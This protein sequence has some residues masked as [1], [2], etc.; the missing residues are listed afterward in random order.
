MFRYSYIC[1]NNLTA[2]VSVDLQTTPDETVETIT[3]EIVGHI[4]SEPIRQT[5]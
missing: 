2:L 3:V 1:R 4:M 5:R